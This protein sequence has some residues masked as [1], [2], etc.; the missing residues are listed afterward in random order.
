M[1]PTT[2][3]PRQSSAFTLVEL[4]LVVVIIGI[5]ASVTIP[6]YARSFDFMKLR[7]AAHDVAAT[8]EYARAVAVLEERTLRVEFPSTGGCVVSEEDPP[9]DRKPFETLRHDL[10][11]GVTVGRIEF[12]DTLAAGTD[13]VEFR[14]D[15]DCQPCTIKISG[16]GG[17]MYDVSVARGVGHTTVMLETAGG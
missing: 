14:P 8:L 11:D 17:E 1:L 6:H 12:A 10:P 9:A 3:L 2:R 5:L 16:L 7:S 4:L 13:Y 15:G